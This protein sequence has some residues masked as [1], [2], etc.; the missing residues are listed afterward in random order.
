MLKQKDLLQVSEPLLR[1]G[2]P[3]LESAV[4]MRTADWEK[5]STGA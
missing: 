2:W 5:A 4:R 1:I 3:E